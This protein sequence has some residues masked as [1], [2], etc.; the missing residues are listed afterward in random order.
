MVLSNHTRPIENRP[1]W[2]KIAVGDD[3]DITLDA[4]Q[5]GLTISLIATKGVRLLTCGPAPIMPHLVQSIRPFGPRLSPM[6]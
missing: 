6:S 2:A 4:L 1:R 3:P 5:R